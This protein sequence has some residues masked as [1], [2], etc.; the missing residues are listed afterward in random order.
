MSKQKRYKLIACEILFR[1]FCQC[2]TDCENIIDIVFMPK[3]LHDMGEAKMVSILQQE[4]DKVKASDYDAILL[5]YAL[6]N[7]GIRGLNATIPMVVARAHDCITLLMGSKEKYNDYFVKNPGTYFKSPGWIERG[8]GCLQNDQSIPSQMGISSSYEGYVELYGEENAKY[9][10]ETIGDWY[11]HY[12]KFTFID[13][14]VGNIKVYK[15]QTKKEAEKNGW[16]YEEV[17]GDIILLKKLIDGDWN[18]KEFLLVPAGS[19]IQAAYDNEEI[20]TLN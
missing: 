20:I 14:N 1:E 5:G 10:M 18:S 16:E 17:P 2:V 15:E 4:I 19:N 6:C 11:K 3:G 9:F 7:N 8:E 13:T 12:K